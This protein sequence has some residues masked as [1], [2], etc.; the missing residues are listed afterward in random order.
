MFQNWSAQKH[1]EMNK[2]FNK[3]YIDGKQNINPFAGRWWEI[4][5]ENPDRN[6]VPRIIGN[7]AQTAQWAFVH[8]YRDVDN[9]SHVRGLTIFAD[10][11]S[12]EWMVFNIYR[13][14]EYQTTLDEPN[15]FRGLAINFGP[16]EHPGNWQI[17]LD[18][19]PF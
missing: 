8:C 16:L 1:D 4:H 3:E 12:G 6:D 14:G 17:L 19:G 2:E 15:S 11:H 13:Y 5:I 7:I 10:R 18:S 9:S